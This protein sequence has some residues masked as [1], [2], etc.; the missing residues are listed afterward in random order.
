M[1]DQRI[2]YSKILYYL[3]FPLIIC[4]GILFRFFLVYNGFFDFSSDSAV[5]CLQAKFILE[6]SQTPVFFAGQ[7]YFSA[8]PSYILAFIFKFLGSGLLSVKIY[9]FGFSVLIYLTVIFIVFKIKGAKYALYTALIMVVLPAGM[10]V[11][12]LSGGCGYEIFNLYSLI[13][14]WVIYFYFNYYG[15]SGK[16]FVLTA[17]MAGFGWYIHPMFIYYIVLFWI[18]NSF[19]LF[20]IHCTEF[21]FYLEKTVVWFIFFLIGSILS[22]TMALKQVAGKSGYTPVS[23]FTPDLTIMLKGLKEIFGSHF[24]EL[25]NINN[26]DIFVI[27][28]FFVLLYIC[29]LCFVALSLHKLSF[30][31]SGKFSLE[32]I[33]AV[34]FAVMAVIHSFEK[35]IITTSRHLAATVFIYPVF[36]ALFLDKIPKKLKFIFVSALI[37]FNLSTYSNSPRINDNRNII[38]YLKKNNLIYGFADYWLSYKLVF[39][40]GGSVILSPLSG[41]RFEDY[42]LKVIRAE[43]KFYLFDLTD[44]A[45][46]AMLDR[47]LDEAKNIGL[48][49]E[50]EFVGE[51]AVIHSL[52][53]CRE[54]N[55]NKVMYFSPVYEKVEI[56]TGQD[57]INQIKEIEFDLYLPQ[58]AFTFITSIEADYRKD[59]FDSAVL[60]YFSITDSLTNSTIGKLSAHNNDFKNQKIREYIFRG[61]TARTG[62]V[63]FRYSLE[64]DRINAGYLCIF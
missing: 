51:F 29:V 59:Y 25:L 11:L 39:F 19:Y 52:K 38:N 7:T 61:Y 15:Q 5:V 21:I 9:V 18:I 28:S 2:Q 60:A 20:Y 54:R 48:I 32:S 10:N 45:Q 44:S 63:I 30:W 62:K 6:Q 31:K 34:L 56:E 64:N 42:A 23:E 3:I 4:A 53:I 13:F 1:N 17:V 47:F 58:N 50:I 24:P 22:W 57:K 36:I 55:I 27:K 16:Y 46:K 35:D 37:V 12:H 14:L 49:Y 33:L 26:T 43:N 40:S 41:G 8:I